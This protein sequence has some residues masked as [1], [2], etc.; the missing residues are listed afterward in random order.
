MGDGV[1]G[2]GLC[3]CGLRARAAKRRRSPQGYLLDLLIKETSYLTAEE[4]LA[5]DETRSGGSM[6]PEVAAALEQPLL[7]ADAKAARAARSLCQ[8]EPLQ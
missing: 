5:R 4:V 7:T 2:Q 3:R 8:V 1:A 6:P